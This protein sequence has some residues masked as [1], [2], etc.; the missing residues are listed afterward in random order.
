MESGSHP[1]RPGSVWGAGPRQ[2][3]N[4]STPRLDL[5]TRRLTVEIPTD[6]TDMQ[7]RQPDL[8][9]EWRL[10][11]RS[12]FQTYLPRGYRGVVFF[13]AREARRGQYLLAQKT[14]T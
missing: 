14:A 13:L 6:F 3:E 7:S 8:A 11:T 2:G 1:R 5:E 12:I 4:P 10:N 9:M